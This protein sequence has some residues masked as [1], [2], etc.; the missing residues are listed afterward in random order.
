MYQQYKTSY[1]LFH[2]ESSAELYPDLI[3]VD[4]ENFDFNSNSFT[5]FH[6]NVIEQIVKKKISVDDLEEQV[7][8][9]IIYN[10]LPGGNTVLHLLAENED[11][12]IAI[13]QMSHPR[14]ESEESK[15]KYHVPLLPNLKKLTAIH[16]C[17]KKEDYKSIDTILKYLKF[18]EIDHHSRAIK[19]TYGEMIQK[20]LPEFIP[21][22]ESRLFQTEQV[23]QVTKG[24]LREDGHG[25]HPFELWFKEEDLHERLF[26]VKPIETRIKCE[27]IDL[28]GVYHYLDDEFLELF[29]SLAETDNIELFD[30]KVI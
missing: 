19:S 28:P 4:P 8:W 22:L 27:F 24:A 9:Q 18:Y 1:F 15:L 14:V 26:R 16:M 11:Q 6:W 12:L 2:K 21:Y 13:F 10:I 17:I 5:Y 3:T 7:I 20:E 30:Q 29:E 25:M 23:K